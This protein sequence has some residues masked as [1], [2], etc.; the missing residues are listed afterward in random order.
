M[1]SS[2]RAPRCSRYV[3]LYTLPLLAF[4]S[5]A[6]VADPVTQVRLWQYVAVRLG[7]CYYSR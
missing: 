2:H 5:K 1:L 4:K 7:F 6:L 3:P